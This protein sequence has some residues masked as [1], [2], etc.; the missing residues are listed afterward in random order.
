MRDG[1]V[2]GK[3]GEHVTVVADCHVAFAAGWGRWRLALEEGVEHPP[4]AARRATVVQVDVLAHV[5]ERVVRMRTARPLDGLQSPTCSRL[6]PRCVSATARAP[7]L[8]DGWESYVFPV[9]VL[10]VSVDLLLAACTVELGE[11]HVHVDHQA[12]LLGVDQRRVAGV[13]G[14]RVE[15]VQLAARAGWEPAGGAKCAYCNSATRHGALA[16]Y[17]RRTRM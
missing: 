3:I 12:V 11:G 14:G 17:A 13:V 10:A 1:A 6:L 16:A 2:P 9:Q 8:C 4:L 7:A 5:L 15:L